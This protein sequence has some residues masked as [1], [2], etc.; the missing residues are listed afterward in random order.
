MAFETPHDGS[1]TVLTF[2]G[3]AYTVT[4]VVVSATDPTAAD[5]KIAVSHLG[6]TAGET[7]KTL[8]LPLAGAASGE[9]GR[10][11]TFDYIG[12]TFIADKSTGTFALTIG[13]TALDG[14]N[15]KKGTVTS[16]T[17]TLATQDAIRGQAT[18]KLER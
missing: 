8:D 10:N 4:S 9:T 16:S 1:G 7:A 18:I 15:G 13:G 2:G 3:T 14:V 12:K 11:V 6:Q 17:L 5:D